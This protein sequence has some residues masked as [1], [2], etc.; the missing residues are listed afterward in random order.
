MNKEKLIHSQS[1][2]H[3]I[4]AS[5][6]KH[7]SY[8]KKECCWFDIKYCYYNYLLLLVLVLLLVLI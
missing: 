6:A 4:L 7:C 2:I 8:L 5:V 3:S 1:T